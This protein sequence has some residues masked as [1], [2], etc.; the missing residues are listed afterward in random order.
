MGIDKNKLNEIDFNARNFLDW[1]TTIKDGWKHIVYGIYPEDFERDSDGIVRIKDF[2]QRLANLKRR[3]NQTRQDNY[4]PYIINQDKQLSKL[5]RQR[6]ARENY[7][8]KW[9]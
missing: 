8:E 2:A 4:Y 5:E 3:K 1:T 7:V 6:K 9:N